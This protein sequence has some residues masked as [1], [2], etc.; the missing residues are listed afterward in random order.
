MSQLRIMLQSL[1][2]RPTAEGD[3][4]VITQSEG[5][6]E[7]PSGLE[8]LLAPSTDVQK[9]A[10][11]QACR[12][13]PFQAEVGEHFPPRPREPGE[14]EPPG[15]LQ[16]GG[17]GASGSHSD[18]YKEP[19]EA[20]RQVEKGGN[21]TE[22][23]GQD[24]GATGS[25]QSSPSTEG[26]PRECL[27]QARDE[28]ATPP[29]R[30]KEGEGSPEYRRSPSYN[31][32][33]PGDDCP[34]RPASEASE[35]VFLLTRGVDGAQ[36][37]LLLHGGE[38]L[39]LP[40]RMG[41]DG[42]L[43]G[44]T[45]KVD[46]AR[47]TAA[48]HYGYLAAGGHDGP[49]WTGGVLGQMRVLGFPS[50]GAN[51]TPQSAA[52][53]TVALAAHQ[54]SASGPSAWDPSSSTD[55][56]SA[57]GAPTAHAAKAGKDPIPR[58]FP[59]KLKVGP[60]QPTE[61]LKPIPWRLFNPRPALIPIILSDSTIVDGYA[62]MLRAEQLQPPTAWHDFVLVT[63]AGNPVVR[64]VGQNGQ[65]VQTVR[66]RIKSISPDLWRALRGEGDRPRQGFWVVPMEDSLGT[67]SKSYP[68]HARLQKIAW[69]APTVTFL[70]TIMSHEP[71]WSQRHY[72][73]PGNP[74]GG[75]DKCGILY[76]A[77]DH[78]LPAV[79]NFLV[80]QWRPFADKAGIFVV[81][82][83]N[84]GA[85]KVHREFELQRQLR[86]ALEHPN[87]EGGAFLPCCCGSTVGSHSPS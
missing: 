60:Y 33:E 15:V 40:A 70:P 50:T 64:V 11:A 56:P 47:W 78:M 59:K 87:G 58:T 20:P 13:Q 7:Q 28:E 63:P 54:T 51:Y 26:N 39:I 72:Q 41:T 85:Q 10:E 43:W 35:E 9:E 77:G 67:R 18:R 19:L 29:S 55:P 12:S 71:L 36:S 23:V 76:D 3:H 5:P 68:A 21:P 66:D 52:P 73:I 86:L 69:D 75:R 57:E 31:E 81:M 34:S 80:Q 45:G 4:E 2:G 17:G 30:A 48:G 1:Q 6:S 27:G 16:A 38:K 46:A 49:N 53:T 61:W 25:C 24:E 62:R 14:V 37:S 8:S 79:L 82:G 42:G 44:H 32:Q 65:C 83:W 84:A 74:A 22:Q